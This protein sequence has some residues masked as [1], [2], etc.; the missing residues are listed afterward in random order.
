[1]KRWK[2]NTIAIIAGIVLGAGMTAA[3]ATGYHSPMIPPIVKPPIVVPPPVVV[4]PVVVPPPVVTPPAATPAPV[5]PAQQPVSS[6]K[7]LSQWPGYAAF[8]GVAIYFGAVI[9]SHM[10]WCA[11]DDRKPEK[12]RKCYRPIRDGMPK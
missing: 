9:R 5:A 10:I 11:E 3:F 7:G 4:P 6:A 1:M 2:R 12:D 8:A